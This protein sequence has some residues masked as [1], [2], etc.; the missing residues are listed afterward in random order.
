MKMHFKYI[1]SALLFVSYPQYTQASEGVVYHSEDEKSAEVALEYNKTTGSL[2]RYLCYRDL[3]YYFE[4]YVKGNQTLDYGSGT[5]ISTQYLVDHKF[6]VTGVDVSLEMIIQAKEKLPQVSFRLIE[7]EMI[8]ARNESFD[9]VFSSYV[10]FEISNKQNITSYIKEAKRVMKD[11]GVFIAITG[12]KD[13]YSKDWQSFY[14]DFPENK[15]L[16]SGDLA[17]VLLPDVNIEFVDYYWTEEDYQECFENAGM[18]LV[19]MHHPLG[20]ESTIPWKE[21][22]NS[23]PFVIFIAKKSNS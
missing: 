6:D 7:Q 1:V 22:R 15:N 3:P 9:L 4:K 10:F 2:S 14:V 8:P 13:A 23:S 5:G 17:R 11:D 20:H 21:E 16:Q 19:E 18:E 12:S